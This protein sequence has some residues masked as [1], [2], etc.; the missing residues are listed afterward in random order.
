M[1][2]GMP[3]HSLSYICDR[4][5]RR[6]GKMGRFNNKIFKISLALVILLLMIWFISDFNLS[7][8]RVTEEG[9]DVSINFIFPMDQGTFNSSISLM[10][11]IADTKFQCDVRWESS[12]RVVIRL[13]EMSS[14]K[15]Q[16]ARLVISKAQTRIPG[17][18][19]SATI[20]VQFQQSP[21]LIGVSEVN[22]IPTDAPFIVTFNTPM[23]R[24]NINKYIASDTHFEITPVE[25]S[26]YCQWQL[27]PKTPLENNKKYILSFQKG[28]PAISG[29]FME[30]DQIVTLQ[31]PKKPNIT[32]VMP[33]AGS[34]WVEVYPKIIIES[35]EPIKK[36]LLDVDGEI[37]EG[38]IVGEQRA[39]FIL[40]KVLD[41][42]T[43]YTLACQVVSEH[44]EKSE[45]FQFE[46]TTM[47]IEEDRVWVEIVLAKEHKMVVYKGENP[48]RTMPCSGGTAKDPTIRGTYYLK[49]R[50]TQFF[51]KKIN[52]GAANWI[53]I[54]GNYLIHGL[55]RDENWVIKKS[56]EEK[57]GSPASHGCVRLREADAQWMYDNIPQNTM[58]IIHE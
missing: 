57:I 24:G 18:K 42:E 35:N 46:F 30:S 33:K 10:P 16:R 11:D 2:S 49:D 37:L 52:E 34:R 4:E 5:G 22:N 47:P 23:K 27:T 53:R 7:I 58:V 56:D 19:K 26:H 45:P 40:K 54:D 25:G 51:A 50:G 13:K 3:G 39:E 36:A 41:F 31:T 14:I 9:A 15:G 29:L 8:V 38:K 1:F 44:G 17:I 55:P 12:H 32:Q 20:S 6:G 21:K 48:I 43:T 28:M